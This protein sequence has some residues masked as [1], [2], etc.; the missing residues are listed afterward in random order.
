M[1]IAVLPAYVPALYVLGAW[2]DRRG[3]QKEPFELE[4]VMRGQSV[5]AGN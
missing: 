1:I 5:G 3:C 2:E 4:P